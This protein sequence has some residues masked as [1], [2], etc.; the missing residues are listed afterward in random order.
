[1]ILF[2]AVPSKCDWWIR[3]WHIPISGK[4]CE[5]SFGGLNMHLLCMV[6]IHTI[7]GFI[8]VSKGSIK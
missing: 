3:Q 7:L 1:M 8:G 6:V 4:G 2:L 5:I